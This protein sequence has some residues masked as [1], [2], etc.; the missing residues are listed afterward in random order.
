MHR[1]AI[2]ARSWVEGVQIHTLLFQHQC[3]L[4]SLTSLS[5]MVNALRAAALNSLN[6]T[7]LY[8]IYSQSKAL[9]REATRLR[10]SWKCD[11]IWKVKHYFMARASQR[12]SITTYFILSCNKE[13][14]V[15][16]IIVVWNSRTPCIL[17]HSRVCVTQGRTSFKTNG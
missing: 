17:R 8:T 4:Y 9:I 14:Y 13:Q 16:E 7:F 2:A 10:N 3:Q 11:W 15:H 12:H 1:Q 5:M 6:Y